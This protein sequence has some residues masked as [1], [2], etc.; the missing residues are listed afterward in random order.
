MKNVKVYYETAKQQIKNPT[1]EHTQ[2]AID[3]NLG[4]AST[5]DTDL[6]DA[7]NKSH[8]DAKQKEEILA[9]ASEVTTAINDFANWLKDFKNTTPRSFRLGKELYAKKFEHDIQSSYTANEIYEK[10][11]ANCVCSTVGFLIC[12][13]AVS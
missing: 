7:L 10:A 8:L 6:K 11:I 2:L 3:Q 9:R 4:G 5:F 13:F 12:C 1:V